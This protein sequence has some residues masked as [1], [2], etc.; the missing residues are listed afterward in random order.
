M[1]RPDPTTQNA[2]P[3]L[4]QLWGGAQLK[5]LVV[6]LAVFVLGAG[7]GVV[8]DRTVMTQL[9]FRPGGGP[10]LG[11]AN[12]MRAF[13]RQ[14]DLAPEQHERVSAILEGSLQRAHSMHR[15]MRPRVRA[16]MRD[17]SDKIRA[18]LTPEQRE[19]FDDFMSEMRTHHMH[20]RRRPFGMGRG[21]FGE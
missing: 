11:R 3:S 15:E 8:L 21:R 16:M 5:A 17:T 18:E 20:R 12:I 7:I 4:V 2:S 13:M 6:L 10:L 9:S 14:L 19:R 1:E